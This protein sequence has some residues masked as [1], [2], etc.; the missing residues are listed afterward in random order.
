MIEYGLMILQWEDCSHL[1]YLYIGCTGWIVYNGLQVTAGHCIGVSADVLQFHVPSSLSDGTIQHP[2]VQ[3]QYSVDGQ[4]IVFQDN[5]IG[6]DWAVFEVF[7]NSESGLQPIKAQNA[8][9]GIKQDLNASDLRVTGFGVDGPPPGFGNGSK[10]SDNQTQ[11]THVGS[12]ENS[13]DTTI[14]HTADTQGA[15][16]GS[17]IIDESTGQAIGVHTNGGCSSTGGYNQGTST[18]HSN[19]WNA[20]HP[21]VSFTVDQ[22]RQDDTRLLGTNIGHWN[23]AYFNEILIT[24]PLPIINTTLG[25][26]EILRGYQEMVSNPMEKYRTW[27]RNGIEQTDTVQN[28]RGFT[29]LSDL[30]DMTSRFHRSY[31]NSELI[32]VFLNAPVGFNPVNDVID[33]K[34][35]WFIDY[36]DPDYG[37]NKR[38]QGMDAPF[39]SRSAP[40]YPDYNS[41]YNGNKYLGVFLNQNPQFQPGVPVY[42]VRSF[43]QDVEVNSK[44]L[45]W[46]FESWSYDP[47]SIAL[48]YPYNNTTAVVFKQ[49]G[50][51]LTANLKARRA[52]DTPFATASNQGFSIGPA[53]LHSYDLQTQL[54][55]EDRGNI[56]HSNTEGSVWGK[57]RLLAEKTGSKINSM[58]SLANMEDQYYWRR[59]D[60]TLVVWNKYNPLTDEHTAFAGILI[61]PFWGLAELELPEYSCSYP[62]QLVG[63]GY[64]INLYNETSAIVVYRVDGPA[65]NETFTSLQAWFSRGENQ[66]WTIPGTMNASYPSI[67][68]RKRIDVSHNPH[69]FLVYQ[70]EDGITY[71][72]IS[73]DDDAGTVD[74]GEAEI[75]SDLPYLSHNEHPCVHSLLF[76][77]Y[78]SN[79]RDT[80]HVVWQAISESA[81][82]GGPVE[83]VPAICLREKWDESWNAIKIF[84]TENSEDRNPVVTTEKGGE[85][86]RMIHIAYQEVEG[87]VSHIMNYG[88]DWIAPP[89]PQI[90]DGNFPA[91]T[92]IANDIHLAY[93][94]CHQ[95]PYR[96]IP[97]RISESLE[98]EFR[99]PHARRLSFNLQK[100]LTGGQL[101]TANADLTFEMGEPLLRDLNG[102]QSL[103]F[104]AYDPDLTAG[105]AFRFT[106]LTPSGKSALLQVPVSVLVHNLVRGEALSEEPVLDIFDL[107]LRD[108]DTKTVLKTVATYTT[109]LLNSAERAQFSLTDTFVVE[110]GAWS[111]RELALEGAVHLKS[112]ETGE[113]GFAEVYDLRSGKA[114]QT[115]GIMALSDAL[116]IP[117]QFALTQNYPNPFN[118]STTVSFD[119]PND[120]TVS[121]DIFD[122]TG[123]KIR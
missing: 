63:S 14:R 111:G 74:F 70:T 68:S 83:E 66:D 40:F 36:P 54:I 50:A 84:L 28:H 119:L 39:Y 121:L 59:G 31:T 69:Y 72:E 71:R 87:Q 110:L 37:Y 118:P 8:S 85:E 47:D 34:D 4:S 95:Q 6:N 115:E 52:S 55:Y 23:G 106:P 35:P 20:L 99:V 61:P 81:S 98:H 5:G 2:P 104:S 64:I 101:L 116:S 94:E 7:D 114:V 96:I 11:Q 80:V 10:N 58:P 56:Y 17:P 46:D 29:I 123:R 30:T 103:T 53:V 25:S 19:F 43:Q 60:K 122:I 62:T 48:Q 92:T 120:V 100:S 42:S 75:L 9:L 26:R 97:D 27:E 33:F 76:E 108:N 82:E 22:K 18:Y 109:S 24:L 73:R 45:T 49:D 65:E 93:T 13:S 1:N 41:L 86:F 15:N 112:T 88:E 44:M 21:P 105:N 117:E 51:T 16:S 77:R 107:V 32:N 57:D 79:Y 102:A 91:L 113:I 3:H 90:S 67:D 89:E 38:N 12:N 78:A